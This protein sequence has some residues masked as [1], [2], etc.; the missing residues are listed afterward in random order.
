MTRTLDRARGGW[1]WLLPVWG[2]RA[3]VTFRDPLGM[4]FELDFK[5]RVDDRAIDSRGVMSSI[6]ALRTAYP[7]LVGLE[8]AVMVKLD[9]R[10]VCDELYE[11]ILRFVGQ[12]VRKVPWVVSGDTETVAFRNSE[13]CFAFVPAGESVEFSFY[14]GSENEVEEYV[15]EPTTIRLQAFA[16][17]TLRL[18]EQLLQMV[19]GVDPGLVNSDEDCRDLALSVDE[20][21]KAW[22]EHQLH[23]RR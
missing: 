10:V 7:N 9:G 11:P 15:V 20:G 14:V 19:L 4:K 21:R 17:E 1:L 3:N 16:E 13:N 6:D 2:K 22:K 8:G 23:Q 12:W 5:L 18:G